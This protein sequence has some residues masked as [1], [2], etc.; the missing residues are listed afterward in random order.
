MQGWSRFGCG[1][2]DFV[3]MLVKG[4]NRKIQ[5]VDL[6]IGMATSG[7]AADGRQLV[8]KARSEASEYRQFYGGEIPGTV[9]SERIAGHVHMHTL[10]WYLRPFGASVLIASYDEESG[11]ELSMIAPSGIVNRYSACAI[12][13]SKQGA[14]TELE[15]IDFKTV[16]C[17]DAV[18]DIAKIIYRLHDDIKDKPFELEL[19]W[20][21][22]ESKRRHVMVP[23]ALREEAI[24]IAK[25]EKE[26][27]EMDDDEAADDDDDDD[28]DGGASKKKDKEGTPKTFRSSNPLFMKKVDPKKQDKKTE[29]AESINGNNTN[30]NVDL[31]FI[32]SQFTNM[33]DDTFG[34]VTIDVNNIDNLDKEDK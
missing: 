13:K 14:K 34:V 15:K 27:A 18:K 6:H 25:E 20:V 8:N 17:R 19:S 4:A 11:P 7:L 3:K 30:N 5:S 22:D 33:I 2:G 29:A 1:E 16:T 12:G 10:Y 32:T 23:D 24:R 28:D 21:C 26:K 9:L 31:E